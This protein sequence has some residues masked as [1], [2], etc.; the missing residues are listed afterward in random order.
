MTSKSKLNV[1]HKALQLQNLAEQLSYFQTQLSDLQVCLEPLYTLSQDIIKTIQAKGRVFLCGNGGSAGDVQ[2]LAAEF[3]GRFK[4]ERKALPAIALTVDS[5]ALTAIGNDYGFEHIFSRQLE[6]L[7]HKG[8]VLLAFST[9]G[10]SANVIEAINIAKQLEM[11]TVLFCGR[12][13]GKLAQSPHVDTSLAVPATQTDHIQQMHMILGHML[14][15]LVEDAFSG[16]K[17]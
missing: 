3:T 5:S 6:A 4:R 7:G 14:C 17:I 13:A 15:D 11:H 12:H 9:S 2:H 16:A 1:E 8:D 10:N